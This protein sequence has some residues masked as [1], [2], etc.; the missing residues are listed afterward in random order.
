MT[1]TVARGGATVYP[2]LAFGVGVAAIF[3]MALLFGIFVVL[4]VRPGR[5][6]PGPVRPAPRTDSL[7]NTRAVGGTFVGGSALWPAALVYPVAP[8]RERRRLDRRGQRRRLSARSTSILRHDTT[9]G[10]R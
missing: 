10:L 7:V 4:L 1:D 9:R 5:G 6:R 3:L 2:A 8:T